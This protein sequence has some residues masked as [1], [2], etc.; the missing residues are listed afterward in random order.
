MN[1]SATPDTP[2]ERNVEL[3][4]EERL[5]AFRTP[6]SDF[7]QRLESRLLHQLGEPAAELN[8]AGSPLAM[9]RRRFTRVAIGGLASAAALTLALF[10]QNHLAQQPAEV[11]AAELLDRAEKSLADPLSAGLKSYHLTS[12]SS[13]KLPLNGQTMASTGEQWFSPPNR[14]RTESRTTS[15][16][17]KSQIS[18]A[19]YIDGEFTTYGTPGAPSSTLAV[20]P[21]G[22]IWYRAESSTPGGAGE[23]EVVKREVNERIEKKMVCLKPDRKGET[24]VA[25]RTAYLVENTL[26]DP[27]DA[28]AP[29]KGGRHV[30]AIDKET[31]IPLKVENYNAAGE[32]E[33]LYELTKLEYDIPIP[34][35]I[36]TQIPA[37]TEK[38]PADKLNQ[39]PRLAE[40]GIRVQAPPR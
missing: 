34:D 17:G 3:L 35:S 21:K 31:S 18:G 1:Q 23:G 10:A 5:S 2:N 28:A 24:T 14:T 36:F 6:E 15:A 40:P 38:L 39:L 12:R 27:S 30:M 8:P 19:I 26:C 7:R 22:I 16:D 13:G 11:S 32:L 37:G 33:L 25:G 9:T 20:M 4:L 29:L